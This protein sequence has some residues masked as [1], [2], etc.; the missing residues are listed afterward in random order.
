MIR[1][2]LC[3]EAQKQE[4]SSAVREALLTEATRRQAS[5]LPVQESIPSLVQGLR[6][7]EPR[8]ETAHWWEAERSLFEDF[9]LWDNPWCNPNLAHVLVYQETSRCKIRGAAC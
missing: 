7:E 5:R 2:A 4:P 6:D 3:S 1:E 8:T 9:V